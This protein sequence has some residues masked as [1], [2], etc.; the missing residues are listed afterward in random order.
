[1]LQF[2]FEKAIDSCLKNDRRSQEQ[3]Y[4]YTYEKLISTALRY[5]K[6]REESKWVFNLAMLKVFKSL[7]RYK[8]GTNYLGW[9]NDILIK[10]CIDNLRSNNRHKQ[11]IAPLD[12]SLV[13]SKNKTWNTALNKLATEKIIE[14][15]QSLNENERMVFSMYEIDGYKH[16]EIAEITGIKLNTSKWLL[17][18]AKKELKKKLDLLYDVNVTLND[19]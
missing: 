3:L 14:L 1:M 4:N 2:D 12:S 10:T 16:K 17:A 15:I 18:K 5:T 9:A 8:Q 11:I 6:S 7:E 13:D 19:N